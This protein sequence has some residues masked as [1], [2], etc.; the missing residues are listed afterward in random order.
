M[1]SIEFGM[2]DILRQYS[3]A[4]TTQVV[5]MYHHKDM[6]VAEH[7][8]FVSLISIMVYSKLKTEYPEF[9]PEI[10]QK[11]KGQEVS[12]LA[13]ILVKATL[14]GLPEAILSKVDRDSMLLIRSIAPGIFDNIGVEFYKTG[15]IRDILDSMPP[16]LSKIV[17]LA[18]EISIHLYTEEERKRG[19]DLLKNVSKDALTRIKEMGEYFPKGFI[20]D[21]FTSK[22][23]EL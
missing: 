15:L 9:R 16:I 4:K 12:P 20:A 17:E 1:E 21:L 6:S 8:Y 19:N 10:K 2:M 22:G 18:E 3:R 23:W 11:V 7:S 5:P 14:K 13:Y